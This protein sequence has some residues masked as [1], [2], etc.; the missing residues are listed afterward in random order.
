MR[1]GILGRSA[2]KRRSQGDRQD[3]HRRKNR[4]GDFH[5]CAPDYLNSVYAASGWKPNALALPGPEYRRAELSMVT[6]LKGKRRLGSKRFAQVITCENYEKYGRKRG[7]AHTDYFRRPKARA[8]RRVSFL[9][10]ASTWR[11][12]VNQSSTS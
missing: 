1:S 9:S 2:A 3:C 6:N 5:V 8:T 10:P 4:S 11:S 12:A 7:G